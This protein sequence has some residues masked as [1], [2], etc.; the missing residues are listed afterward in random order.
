MNAINA[1]FKIRDHIRQSQNEWKGA[2]V[3][4]KDMGKGL[5]KVFKDVVNTP[6]NSLT[7]LG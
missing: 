7:T 4:A 2:E 6:N 5:H 3:S 1:R